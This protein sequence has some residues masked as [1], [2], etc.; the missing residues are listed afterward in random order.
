MG[1]T[2]AGALAC[3]TCVWACA[4]VRVT[5]LRNSWQ[6]AERNVWYSVSLMCGLKKSMAAV[7]D[8][9]LRILCLHTDFPMVYDIFAHL[10]IKFL[11]DIEWVNLAIDSVCVEYVH[12]AATNRIFLNLIISS[13]GYKYLY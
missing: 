7:I 3:G 6:V 10:V 9:I 5:S 4:A 11:N 13:L 12:N 2:F 1:G 8:D